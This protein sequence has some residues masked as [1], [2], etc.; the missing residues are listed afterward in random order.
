MFKRFFW[1][2]NM[3]SQQAT[4]KIEDLIKSKPVFIASKVCNH[5]PEFI[6]PHNY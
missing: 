3:V 2:L 6:H 4:R 5:L 1:Q